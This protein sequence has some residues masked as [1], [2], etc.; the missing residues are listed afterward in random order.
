MKKAFTLV[1]MLVVV[2]VLVTLMSIVFKLGSIGSD[3]SNRNTTIVRM[4]RLENCLSGYY[5][6]FGTYPPV[7]LHG[8]RN[9]Y[10]KANNH[11]I[12]TEEENKS[13][14]GWN[15]IGETAEQEA[16]QQ[17]KAA[18]K[19][20]PVDC[21][22]PYPDDAV[23]NKLVQSISEALKKRAAASKSLSEDRKNVLSAGF[24]N[25]VTDN[26]GRFNA[27]SG[28]MD[29]RE[30]QLFRFGLMS[31]L[32]PRYLVMMNSKEELYEGGYSQWDS[33]NEIP[34]NPLTGFKF[35]DW[36]VVR[37]R[38]RSVRADEKAEVANIPSQAVCARW[39]PNLEGIVCCNHDYK[40]YGISIRGD[41]GAS[42]LRADNM[43]IEVFSPGGADSDSTSQQYVLDSATVLDG[44]WREF[45]YYS[46]SPHQTYTLWSAGANGRTFPP[47]V[48]RKAL[49]SKANRCIALWVEDD[50]VR[51][52]N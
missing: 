12:Q 7:G 33:N 37:D 5:A 41:S 45:Y 50:I 4:Q 8:S 21:R 15:A 38:S 47:W 6:A 48:S 52:S 10:L 31:F 40:L 16:W 13:I 20:Q 18:C 14:W 43:D 26:V 1:E 32:L 35:N 25:G 17:V 27:N 23:Y 46:P 30:I 28:E 22:F 36:G 3:Q 39:M 34:C 44:W 11:G 9:F 49:D 2:V 29:W 24:D 51:M 42:E 19:A